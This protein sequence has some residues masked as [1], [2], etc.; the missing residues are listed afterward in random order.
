M[1]RKTEDPLVLRVGFWEVPE[2]YWRH[3]GT[4]G[5]SA[6]GVAP[7]NISMHVLGVPII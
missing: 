3:K 2:V 6:V 7:F 1:V 5:G 4:G